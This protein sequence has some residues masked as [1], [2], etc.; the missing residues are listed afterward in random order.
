MQ[1]HAAHRRVSDIPIDVLR[2]NDLVVSVI[3]GNR[4]LCIRERS[5]SCDIH[6]VNRDVTVDQ[7]CSIAVVCRIEDVRSRMEGTTID[8]EGTR[9]DVEPIANHMPVRDKSI[10]LAILSC[11]EGAAKQFQRSPVLDD[12][13]LC[14]VEIAASDVYTS[15]VIALEQPSAAVEIA[16]IDGEH[17]AGS[18]L[19]CYVSIRRIA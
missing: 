17:R 3:I 13:V 1:P 19:P 9:I 5:I 12:A 4:P 18:V 15:V 10:R 16:A 14:I 8:I 6:A 2:T 11:G 7:L